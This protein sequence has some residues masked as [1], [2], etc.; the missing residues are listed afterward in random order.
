MFAWLPWQAKAGRV[1]CGSAQPFAPLR[2]YGTLASTGIVDTNSPQT[3][4]HVHVWLV[5]AP[6]MLLRS[7]DCVC[8]SPRPDSAVRLRMS[9]NLFRIRRDSFRS[10]LVLRRNLESNSSDQTLLLTRLERGTART[11]LTA[12]WTDCDVC[13]CIYA[14]DHAH[15]YILPVFHETE[16]LVCVRMVQECCE[17]RLS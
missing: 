1:R 15:R 9:L 4:G 17:K 6:E 10:A 16:C 12:Q 14:P 11:I 5:C 2:W 13:A 3:S 7:L 8:S